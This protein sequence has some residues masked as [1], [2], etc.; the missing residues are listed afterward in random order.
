MDNGKH[1]ELLVFT[2]QHSGKYIQNSVTHKKQIEKA[3]GSSFVLSMENKESLGIL[4]YLE[5]SPLATDFLLDHE[6]ELEQ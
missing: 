4:E 2:H 6:V 1:L 5:T 3:Q